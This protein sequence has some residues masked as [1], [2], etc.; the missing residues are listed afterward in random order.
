MIRF[1]D[2]FITPCTLAGFFALLSFDKEP[3]LKLLNR[4]QRCGVLEEGGAG[5][6]AGWGVVPVSNFATSRTNCFTH[7]SA[8]SALAPLYFAPLLSWVVVQ[9]TSPSV[10]TR[11]IA[12][13]ARSIVSVFTD[14]SLIPA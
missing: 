3:G 13:R 2:Q 10:L 9:I 5:V 14:E 12:T 7:M 6:M 8:A 1:L 11:R 4:N